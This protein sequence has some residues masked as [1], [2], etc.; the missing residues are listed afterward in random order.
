M[1]DLTSTSHSPR[2]RLET[3]RENRPSRCLETG[4]LSMVLILPISM[5]QL[6]TTLTKGSTNMY[7]STRLRCPMTFPKW[8]RLELARHL[9]WVPHILLA[10]V[11]KPTTTISWSA[12]LKQLE[13]GSWNAWERVGKSHG[14]PQ[15]CRWNSSAILVAQLFI[16]H[17]WHRLV[18][19][20]DPGYQWELPTAIPNP[21]GVPGTK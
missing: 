5:F 11:A 19:T 21:L 16:G 12:R 6:L 1:T 3:A 20:K 4:S 18:V 10:T 2:V 14:A 15:A 7:S 8:K 13:G 17:Y 9:W